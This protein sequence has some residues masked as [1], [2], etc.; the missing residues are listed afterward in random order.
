M[1]DLT[2]LLREQKHKPVAPPVERRANERYSLQAAN[3]EFSYR[4]AKYPCQ[5]VNVSM[6][7]CCLRMERRFNAG[8]LAPVEVL[9]P[10]FGLTLRMVG[11]TQWIDEEENLLGIRFV[12]ASAKSK[13]QLAGLITCLIDRDAAEAV[14]EVVAQGSKKV[15]AEPEPEEA[16]GIAAAEEEDETSLKDAKDIE[17]ADKA[18]HGTERRVRSHLAAEW[19]AVLRAPA[20]RLHLAG[21]LIDLS[22]NGCIFRSSMPFSAIRGA[23]VEVESEIRG[24][25]MR[26]AGLT[27]AIYGSTTA[28]IQF[29][30]LSPRKREELAQ[31]I[32]ELGDEGAYG[33]KPP[34]PKHLHLDDAPTP[35]FGKQKDEDF[36]DW[37]EAKIHF[38]ER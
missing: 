31:L 24:L 20:Q 10:V 1:I 26:L 35:T 32:E 36:D 8:A 34:E 15:L 29:T 25:H 28:G 18:V 19:P 6:G 37:K 13:N 21:E 9:I 33:L 30:M 7:G 12:H 11:T 27:Q 38:W 16:S 4:G 22:L 23:I 2:Q 3:S 14:Q 5:L 17:A